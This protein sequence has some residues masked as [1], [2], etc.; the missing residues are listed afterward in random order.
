MGLKYL[1]PPAALFVAFGAPR[2][3]HYLIDESSIKKG[4]PVPFYTES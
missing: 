1:F 2:G 4:I 3:A